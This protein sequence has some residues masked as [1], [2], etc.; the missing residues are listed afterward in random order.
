MVELKN[1]SRTYFAEGETEKALI[2]A[3]KQNG[4]LSSGKFKKFN[5]WQNK[6]SRLLRVLN[7]KESLVFVIDIDVSESWDIFKEN[8]KV[9]EG[10]NF[11]IFIQN[12]NLED[13]LIYC[14]SKQ[15]LNVLT[16]DFYDVSSKREFKSKFSQ[17]KNLA[18]TLN[19]QG[20]EHSKLWQR[21]QRFQ[22]FDE[23]S[24]LPLPF[25]NHST[26]FLL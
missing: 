3:L 13:E 5:F 7:K 22:S 15:H 20:F 12:Q 9:L 23:L 21:F 24:Q 6:I 2:G 11:C 18:A 19:N 17:D 26:V 14:C 1:E 16:R 25:C 8:I 10:Y 4:I